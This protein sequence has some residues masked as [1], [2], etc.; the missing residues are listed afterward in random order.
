MP[1]S[2]SRSTPLRLESAIAALPELDDLRL[3][4][5]ALVEA[6]RSAES[7]SRGGA[8]H[9]ATV[10]RRLAD[11]A[12]V[13]QRITG[14]AER[15]RDRTE[16]VMKQVVAAL[17]SIE[18]RDE[19]GA[20]RRLVDAGEIEE[21]HGRLD[22]AERYYEKALELGRRPRD[23]S[24]E[25]LALRRLARVA[26]T[27]GQLERAMALYTRSRWV[28]EDSRDPT[29]AVVGC[30]GAG[31]VLADQGRWA[32]ARDRY[33]QGIERVEDRASPEFIHLCTG[34]SVAERRLG[35][36]ASSEAWL[37]R[38][39]AEGAAAADE[40]A[41]AYL[42]HARAKLHVARGETAEAEAV[43]E[44]ALLRPLDPA[45]R[46]IVLIN[47]A[48]AQLDAARLRQSEETARRA[49]DEAIAGGALAHLP[50]VY[51]VL[52]EIARENGDPEGFLFF[53]QALD[54][55]RERAMPESEHAAVQRRY[56]LFDAAL[57]HGEP[58]AARLRIAMEIYRSLGS[59]A[60]AAEVERE[61][62]AIAGKSAKHN[63]VQYGDA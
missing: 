6:S 57:G 23:R 30:L 4:R 44:R 51:L 18:A 2:T 45:A 7:L 21:I 28:A 61:L 48:E 19:A 17:R 38:A 8:A 26:R 50:H 52:G 13:E 14:L 10:D 37:E 15:V 59:P 29:G 58:A 35:D 27:R 63:E 12:G 40:T 22:E 49:E 34:L 54:I 53:E 41:A 56:G 47:L 32:E 55:V 1:V 39:A 60:E 31:H 5:E 9:L 62:E 33:L 20:A 25:A 42:D 46:V 16:R 24:G 11:L 36:L 43:F 3:L